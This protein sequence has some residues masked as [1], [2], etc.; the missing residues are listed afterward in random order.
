MILLCLLPA[1]IPKAINAPLEFA[2]AS[3]R[4]GNRRNGHAPHSQKIMDDSLA[5]LPRPPY[6]APVWFDENMPMRSMTQLAFTLP[7]EPLAPE[8]L[9][10]NKLRDADRAVHDWYRFVLSYP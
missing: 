9:R 4:R 10:H 1:G 3:P 6:N 5:W 8:D 7:E 2:G